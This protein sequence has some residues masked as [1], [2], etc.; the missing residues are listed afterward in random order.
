MNKLT[1][2]PLTFEYVILD[3]AAAMLEPDAVGCLLHGAKAALLVGDQQQLPPFS[4]WKDADT[5]RYTVSLMARIAAS[6]ESA[7][8]MTPPAPARRGTGD[9]AAKGGAAGS[10][11]GADAAGGKGGG[12]TAKAVAK[13]NPGQGCFLLTEQYRMHPA[14]NKIVSSTFYFS[15]LKTAPATE[16]AR[17]HPLPVIF[18]N[19]AN[20]RE[21]FLDRSCFN[22]AEAAAVIS[23]A[24]HCHHY[25]G[26]AHERI[27]ILTFY[28]S[29]IHI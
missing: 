9:A 7:V 14:I 1:D 3:E 22:S 28:L 24:S 10:G 21:E 6:R 26:F 27:N 11:A 2:Q 5:A 19:M 15:K 12:S 17:Q 13:A 8:R 16:R 20:G 25:L 23:I 29:L 4:K 18:V